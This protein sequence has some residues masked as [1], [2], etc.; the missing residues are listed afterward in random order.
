MQPSTFK[1]SGM[2]ARQAGVIHPEE[3]TAH[4]E[5]IEGPVAEITVL[6]PKGAAQRPFCIRTMMGGTRA[7][8]SFSDAVRRDEKALE[9][10]MEGHAV[11]LWKRAV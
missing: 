7:E 5:R 10:L 8:F 6:Q 11:T 4:I 3:F 2:F 1:L 9:L